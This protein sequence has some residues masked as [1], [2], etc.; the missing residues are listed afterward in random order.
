M[1]VQMV[2][3]L[4]QF[5]WEAQWLQ[6]VNEQHIGV[7]LLSQEFIDH[8]VPGTREGCIVKDIRKRNSNI[9]P[10]NFNHGE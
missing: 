7:G 1:E 10:Q 3:Q 9:L 5:E 2:E 8:P 6:N 4:L